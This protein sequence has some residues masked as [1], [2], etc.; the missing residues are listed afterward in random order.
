VPHHMKMSVRCMN[1]T[2]AGGRCSGTSATV[3]D[4][5]HVET[6]CVHVCIVF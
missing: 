5:A 4:A 1:A 2:N 3:I 6:E